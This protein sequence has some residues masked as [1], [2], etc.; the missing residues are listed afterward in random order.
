VLWSVY[1]ARQK[2]IWTETSALIANLFG[3][4]LLIWALPLYGIRA[5]AWTMVA[6][7]G[8]Q[9]LCLM[10]GLGR[11]QSASGQPAAGATP[12]VSRTWVLASGDQFR[13]PPP[14]NG[15]ATRAELD[16]LRAMLASRDAEAQQRIAWWHVAAPSYRWA[17]IATEEALRAGL[18]VNI[19]SR[20]LAVLHTALADAM[21]AAWDSKQ[22]HNRPR[23]HM[24]DPTLRPT[25]ATPVVSSYPDE[26]AVAGAVAAAV[27][28]EVFPQRAAE[29]TRLAE[30]AGRMR[31]LAGVAYPSDVAAGAALGRQVATA[32]LERARR[33]RPDGRWT[34]HVDLGS[35][36]VADRWADL[37]IA[38]WSTQWNYGPGFEAALLDAYGIHPDPERTAYYRLLW[39]LGP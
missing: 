34:G 25:V 10:P 14:P 5:A 17:Q 35:L 3:L 23:P 1:G 21:V 33:D 39:D 30:E 7:T 11:T 6:R 15:Q 13:L 26:H 9:L 20:H 19:A 8:L 32:A 38:T 28:T 36:G 4:L 27:L 12:P 29:F 16:Q 37:A 18:P 31:L 22:A 24:T 2:F